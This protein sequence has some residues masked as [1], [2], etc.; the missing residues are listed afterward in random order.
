[1]NL[2]STFFL[3]ILKVGVKHSFSIVNPSKSTIIY[4]TFSKELKL[5]SL[6]I[7]P[8]SAII[9]S[10]NFL[11]SPI[12]KISLSSTPKIS[13][14]TGELGLIIAIILFLNEFP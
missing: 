1:M 13:A 8:K 7:S 5:T 14:K 12:F 10:F 11:S 6:A 4:L 2:I 9:K 3:T